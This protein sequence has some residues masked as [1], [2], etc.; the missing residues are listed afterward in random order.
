MR[1][2]V[3]DVV[4]VTVVVKVQTRKRRPVELGNR[5]VMVVVVLTSRGWNVGEI[6]TLLYV[7]VLFGQVLVPDFVEDVGGVVS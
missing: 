7:A 3:V 1:S 4:G 5:I 6:F 2:V